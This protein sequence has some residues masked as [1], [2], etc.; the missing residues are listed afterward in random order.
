[1]RLQGAVIALGIA[2]LGA[3]PPARSTTA[4]GKKLVDDFA[5]Q[6]GKTVRDCQSV[7]CLDAAEA[8]RW[9][10]HRVSTESPTGSTL[11][12]ID[13]FVVPTHEGGTRF[14][15]FKDFGAFVGGR[16]EKETCLS[17]DDTVLGGRPAGHCKLEVVFDPRAQAHGPFKVLAET[18]FSSLRLHDS[19]VWEAGRV[20][21]EG[22]NY[23][24][25]PRI[26][27]IR[28]SLGAEAIIQPGDQVGRESLRFVEWHEAPGGECAD[29]T[30]P[31]GQLQ[32][33]CNT[34]CLGDYPSPE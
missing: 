29:F 10:A 24:Q 11:V 34:C 16:V 13:E 7:E 20:V 15:A 8:K 6:L 9:P 14:V 18:P 25:P 4:P 22:L 3:E 2:L 19:R 30:T 5:A 17:R 33:L 32:Q 23:E 31:A 21:I 26:V 27:V 28:A 1:V 12:F